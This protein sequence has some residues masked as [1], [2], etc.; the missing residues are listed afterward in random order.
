MT[1]L[2]ESAVA[3]MQ[4]SLSQLASQDSNTIKTGLQTLKNQVIGTKPQSVMSR[5][6]LTSHTDQLATLTDHL[7]DATLASSVVS[8]LCE[9]ATDDFGRKAVVDAGMVKG[10]ARLAEGSNSQTNIATM[11]LMELSVCEARRSA[12][13]SEDLLPVLRTLANEAEKGSTRFFAL[14]A[15]AGIYGESGEAAAILEANDISTGLIEIMQ[16]CISGGRFKGTSW[17]WTETWAYIRGVTATQTQAIFD[18][19]LPDPG[20]YPDGYSCAFGG[21]AAQTARSAGRGQDAL[22]CTL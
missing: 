21:S 1:L 17:L 13:R 10:I 20:L 3:S 14:I 6:W 8:F 9:F 16:V 5:R 11:I 12:L 2:E 18:Q 15:S 22:Y 19:P 7:G 4:A